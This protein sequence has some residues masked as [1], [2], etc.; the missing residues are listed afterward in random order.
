MRE[1]IAEAEEIVEKENL[2]LKD[3]QRFRAITRQKKPEDTL[4]LANSESMLFQR[5]HEIA[6]KEGNYDW[7]EPE[8]E[9]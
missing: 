8:D 9:Y 7:L 5:L 2:T 4:Y 3:Y 6:E 1:I